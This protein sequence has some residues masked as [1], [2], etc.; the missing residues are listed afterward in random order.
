MVP[1]INAKELNKKPV[2]RLSDGK[3]AWDAKTIPAD[4]MPSGRGFVRGSEY[5]LPTT[6]EQVLRVNVQSGELSEPIKTRG[7]PGNLVWHEGAV[8]SQ[9]VTRLTNFGSATSPGP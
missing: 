9:S 2:Y 4:G 1:M 3:P 6:A 5:Y 7:V 8:I